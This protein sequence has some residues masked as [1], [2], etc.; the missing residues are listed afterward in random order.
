[1]SLRRVQAAREG[2]SHDLHMARTPSA[3]TPSILGVLAGAAWKPPASLGY[4]GRDPGISGSSAPGEIMAA[5]GRLPAASP[6]GPL[7]S[8]VRRH[9]AG[10]GASTEL[11]RA[12]TQILRV[13]AA[14]KSHKR[15]NGGW[16]ASCSLSCSGRSTRPVR[17]A[18]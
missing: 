13:P 18:R 12:T 2:S 5:A 1:M 15:A 3:L 8:T 10:S 17:A 4:P 7:C 16:A 6:A 14:L 9:H 11:E